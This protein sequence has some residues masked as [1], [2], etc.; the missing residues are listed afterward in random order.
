M[1]FDCPVCRLIPTSDRYV[2][3]EK[4]K[5]RIKKY[6]K[7][8]F[9]AI[10]GDTVNYL[11]IIIKGRVRT[12]MVSDLGLIL[13]IE[14]LAAPHPLAAAFL[15]SED[16]KFP[17]DVIALEDVEIAVATKESVEQQLSENPDFLRG[18]MMFNANRTQF[19][20]E[21]IKIFLQKSI[22]AKFAYYILRI[23]KSGD[24]RLDKSLTILA[25]YFGVERPSLSRCISEMENEGII[26]FAKGRGKILNVDKLKKLIK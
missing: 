10:Q 12:E 23:A 5:F 19:L 3:I 15:F 18:F 7:G 26:T 25:E 20:S 2:F 22:K 16:N 14:D 17:V 1:L 11:Y 24:F 21:R 6:K 4:L 8:E 9:V 13:H